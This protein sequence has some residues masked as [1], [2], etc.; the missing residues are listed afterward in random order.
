MQ[1]FISKLQENKESCSSV[2]QSHAESV[3]ILSDMDLDILKSNQIY[4]VRDNHCWNFIL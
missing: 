1:L 4:V 3:C 2:S